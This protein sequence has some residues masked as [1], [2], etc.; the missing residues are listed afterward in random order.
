KLLLTC[1][2]ALLAGTAVSFGQAAA[3]AAAP[4]MS[5]TATAAVVSQYMFR[6]M[7]LS[8]GGLQ[9]AIEM[10]A[11]NLTLG[12]W[13]NFPFDGDKVPD[14][15]DPEIDL[16]GSYAFALK[17]GITLAPGFTSYHFP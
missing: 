16:Y 11:G 2:G 8:D 14:S 7:R 13:S 5:F 9:P 15:S 10:S 3:P 4:S 6:G 1:A 12:A 17:E